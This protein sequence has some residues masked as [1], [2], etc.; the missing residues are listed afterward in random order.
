MTV[1][2]ASTMAMPAV[3]VVVIVSSSAF[4]AG[5]V[6]AH[7]VDRLVT[8]LVTPAVTTPVFVVSGGHMHVNGAHLVCRTGRNDH[9]LGIDH[10]RW[11]LIA[12]IDAAVHTGLI[13]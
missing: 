1:A 2:V 4:P 11:R 10:G 12:D 5:I 9:G 6:V 8:G 3:M 13:H 7:K